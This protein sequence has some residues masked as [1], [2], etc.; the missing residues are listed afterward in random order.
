[1]SGGVRDAWDYLGHELWEP[2]AEFNRA[3]GVAP[4]DLFG[5]LFAAADDYLSPRPT[6]Q[7]IAEAR[8]DPSAAR[9]RFLSLRA[10][11]FAGEIEVIWFL[12]AV[13]KVVAD[14]E[15]PGYSDFY[16][17]RLQELLRKFN[18]RYRLDA[19]CTFCFLLPGSFA[20]LYEELHRINAANAHLAT[21]LGDFEHAFNQYL[22]SETET[23]LRQCIA[24][25]SKYAE[26]LASVTCNSTGSLGALTSRLTDWPHATVRESLSKLY[27]FCSDYPNIRHAGN[28]ASALRTLEARDAT[29]L[30]VLFLTFS[31]YLTPALDERVVLGI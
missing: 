9:Q 11:D 29:T 3:G 28:A 14:Y 18:L 19:P 1:M 12:E 5:D 26:G 30:S 6:A 4:G 27:G 25:A 15:M 20:N 22:R 31:G 7:E 10:A 16:R 17:T 2:L 21:L 23:D 24:N 13:D 8:S